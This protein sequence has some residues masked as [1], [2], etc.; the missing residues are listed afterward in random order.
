MAFM[1]LSNEIRVTFKT[2]GLGE[3]S[4]PNTLLTLIRRAVAQ[5]RCLLIAVACVAG[6]G[7]AEAQVIPGDTPGTG[8]GAAVANSRS[9]PL[10]GMSRG[11]A[12]SEPEYQYRPP[13]ASQ[14]RK[15]VSDP[16]AGVRQTTPAPSYDR[17]RAY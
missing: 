12:S 9:R 2:S 13:A 3:S 11:G 14:N 5:L 1:T 10:L 15:P 8:I 6:M 16:W 7:Q 17:H 4:L